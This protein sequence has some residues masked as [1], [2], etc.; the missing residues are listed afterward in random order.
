MNLNLG[1]I[2]YVPPPS[3]GCSEVF[4]A[5]IRKFRTQEKVMLYSDYDYPDVVKIKGSPEQARAAADKSGKP[6]RFAINNLVFLTGLR[7]AVKTGLTHIIYLESDC[8]V[9]CDLWDG[10][11]WDE[12]FHIGRPCIA[13]GTLACYNPS[14]HSAEAN[15]RWQELVALN[16]RQ[17]VPVATYGWLPA[18][19]KG[20]T[21]VFPNG[22][23]SVLDI[24]WMSKL[25]NIGAG[26]TITEAATIAPWDMQLGVKLWE[27]FGVQSFDVVGYIRCIYSGYGEVL[28]SEKERLGWLK[29]GRVVAIHQCKSQETV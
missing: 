3:V 1:I 14:N 8:R 7:I 13:A 25:F 26:E 20:N 27:R 12:Y 4:M 24:S 9:G 19:K 5:N 16:W 10:R 17:N 15:L 22:A 2:G 11:M 6:N 21:C 23:L 18:D 29:E 28:T